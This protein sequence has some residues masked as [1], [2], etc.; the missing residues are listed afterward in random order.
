MAIDT[1]NLVIA[2]THAV[3]KDFQ[4]NGRWILA[5][6]GIWILYV[7]VSAGVGAFLEDWNYFKSLYFT[8][9]NTTTVGFGDVTP[10]SSAGQTLAMVN[11]VIGLLIFGMLVAT[12]TMALQPQS[13]S[14]TM[15]VSNVRE[16]VPEKPTEVREKAVEL[17]PMDD[18]RK[19]LA[20][21]ISRATEQG[22]PHRGEAELA[23]PDLEKGVVDVFFYDREFPNRVRIRLYLG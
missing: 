18:L 4:R 21:L 10:S 17:D 5:V 22:E 13:Y 19:A 12:V 14:G 16:P 8:V 1:I 11:A 20:R 7:L 3:R 15:A 23:R 6:F 9:I 2:P